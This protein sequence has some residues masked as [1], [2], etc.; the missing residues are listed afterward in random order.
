MGI[1]TQIANNQT[2]KQT[3][4][5]FFGSLQAKQK[6]TV[7]PAPA[8]KQSF[9][10]KLKNFFTPGSPDGGINTTAM[11]NM[12]QT[13]VKNAPSF[14]KG[15]LKGVENTLLNGPFSTPAGITNASNLFGGTPSSIKAELQPTNEAEKA[16]SNR[17]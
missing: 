13:T 5:G 16:R 4:T 15:F 7:A 9:G 10:T 17:I 11:K 14:G 12:W 8:P 3:G 6:Q 2:S 1:F